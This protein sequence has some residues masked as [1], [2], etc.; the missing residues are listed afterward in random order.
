MEVISKVD[1]AYLKLE[2]QSKKHHFGLHPGK[3]AD[4]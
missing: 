4:A 1:P 3:W 2:K